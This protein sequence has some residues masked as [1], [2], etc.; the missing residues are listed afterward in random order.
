MCTCLLY[1]VHT[2]LTI[3][4]INYESWES[5][6]VETNI[7][8][9]TLPTNVYFLPVHDVDATWQR[10]QIPAIAYNEAL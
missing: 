2:S 3:A 9:R 6:A 10:I 7:G 4:T 5:T 1:I 8:L